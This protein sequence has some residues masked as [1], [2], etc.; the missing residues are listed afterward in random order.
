MLS[1]LSMAMGGDRDFSCPI[2]DGTGKIKVDTRFT[3]CSTDG[4][5]LQFNLGLLSAVTG[6]PTGA[7]EEALS[8]GKSYRCPDGHPIGAVVIVDSYDNGNILKKY[9]KAEWEKKIADEKAEKVR[10]A[11]EEKATKEDAERE[12]WANNIPQIEARIKTM[13]QHMEQ[14][15]RIRANDS[16]RPTRQD[17]N[18]IITKYEKILDG[19]VSQ[20]SDRCADV[21]YTL[22]SLYFDQAYDNNTQSINEMKSYVRTGR[23]TPPT[24]STP[25]YSKYLKMYWRLSI[26]YPTFLKLPDA[27]FQMSQNYLV[28]GHLDTTRIILE[29]LTLRFPNS[30]R[31]SDAHIR[32]GELAFA[33]KDFDRANSHLKQV[34][35]KEVD[36]NTWKTVQSRLAE[37]KNLRK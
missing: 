6:G 11:E 26:E 14:I 35:K 36:P 15:N 21:M 19:C 8:K 7:L 16:N 28:L 32:L 10:K 23:S 31:T 13:E 5:D 4:E 17:L 12:A 2:C 18:S 33:E 9:T 30:P 22:G 34:K 1:A 25:D 20:K 37:I 3:G 24:P 27:L 29:Q